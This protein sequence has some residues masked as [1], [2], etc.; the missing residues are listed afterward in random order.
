MQSVWVT[1]DD[2]DGLRATCR[3]GQRLGFFGR[4][5]IHPRQVGPINEAYT[6]SADEI[7][8]AREVVEQS[9]QAAADGVG[10][11]RLA[12]GSFVDEAVVRQARR[13]IEIAE[14][15]GAA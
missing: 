8:H 10:A 5:A 2:E 1:I 4:S 7:S 3:D 6:P 15:V 11:L 9:A 14:R 13:T 12:D